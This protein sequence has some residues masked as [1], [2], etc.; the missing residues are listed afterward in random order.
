MQAF[1][2]KKTGGN[3]TAE[4]NGRKFRYCIEI[5]YYARE[6]GAFLC[7]FAL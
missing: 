7:S 2:L 4:K 3:P 5:P 1:F 6:L